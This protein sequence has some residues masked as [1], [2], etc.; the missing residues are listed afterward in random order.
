MTKITSEHGDSEQGLPGIERMMEIKSLGRER[1]SFQKGAL[2]AQYEAFSQ[3]EKAL[4][5][6]K[7]SKIFMRIAVQFGRSRPFVF[8]GSGKPTPNLN[9]ID[10]PSKA[11]INTSY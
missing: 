1:L 2:R 7:S 10:S 3:E 8:T 5:D 9:D 4:V 11:S 6:A